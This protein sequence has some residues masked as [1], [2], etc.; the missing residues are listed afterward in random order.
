[1]KPMNAATLREMSIE[2]LKI[3]VNELKELL[4]RYRFQASQSQLES[5]VTMRTVRQDIARVRT[6]LREKELKKTNN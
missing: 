3:K 2:E 4:F 6:V 5:P 1:M